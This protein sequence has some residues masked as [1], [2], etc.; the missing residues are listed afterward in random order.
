MS[1]VK[2]TR[3]L[4]LSGS[5]EGTLSGSGAGTLNSS[6]LQARSG[7]QRRCLQRGYVSP[8]LCS[9][10]WNIYVSH[11]EGICADID[12]SSKLVLCKVCGGQTGSHACV[13]EL[14]QGVLAQMPS[15]WL[16]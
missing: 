15:A 7:L 13:A 12:V 9:H 16:T 14:R 1:A 4:Q 8:Q 11:A 6:A 2:L 3:G 10:V 5:G